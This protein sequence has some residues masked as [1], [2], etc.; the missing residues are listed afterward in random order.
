[1]IGRGD[2]MKDER[3]RKRVSPKPVSYTSHHIRLLFA[4]LGEENILERLE[5]FN[6]RT[7]KGK[8]IHDSSPIAN[9]FTYLGRE[10]IGKTGKF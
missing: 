10:Y 6:I 1:M 3:Q 7:R 8:I 4:Y 5:N 9:I 2:A